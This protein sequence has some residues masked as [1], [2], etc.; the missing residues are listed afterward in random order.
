MKI[1]LV[2]GELFHADGLADG[3]TERQTDQIWLFAILR[4]RLKWILRDY[5]A[6]LD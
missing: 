6:R 4:T 3:R 1:H 2:G 5:D